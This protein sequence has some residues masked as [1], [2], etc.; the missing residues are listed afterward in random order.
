MRAVEAELVAYLQSTRASTKLKRTRESSIESYF[1]RKVREAGGIARKLTRMKDWPDR[2]VVWPCYGLHLV[3]LKRPK[4]G[5]YSEGQIQLHMKLK[6]MG[7]TVYKVNTRE[8][9]DSYVRTYSDL[10][11][12]TPLIEKTKKLKRA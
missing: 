7:V 6:V 5:R 1:V 9:A 10:R 8:M 11:D 2:I 12:W 4:G 3:E